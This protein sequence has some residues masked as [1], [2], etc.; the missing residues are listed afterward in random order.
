MAKLTPIQ[1]RVLP[2]ILSSKTIREGCKIAGIS[3]SC[4]Y[5]WC[6][7][8]ENFLAEY[9]KKQGRLATTAFEKLTKSTETACDK[10]IALMDSQDENISLRASLSVIEQS[11]IL[12]ETRDLLSRIEI[13]SRKID[14]A[15]L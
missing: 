2:I 10:L 1:E 15:G 4:F 12:E 11:Q 3:K 5:K 14:E 13:L 6:D 8:D 9:H 7:E